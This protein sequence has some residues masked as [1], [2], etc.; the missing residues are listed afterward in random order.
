M[1]D[2]KT[3]IK[4]EL[5]RFFLS[6]LAYVYLISF[7]L[8]SGSCAIYFG[9]FFS[10]GNACLWD[11]FDYQPWIYLL[12]I[13]AI[14]MR[15]WA[16][17]FKSKTVI[18]LLTTPVAISRLVWGKFF[19]AWIFAAFAIM[20][21]FPFWITINIFGNPD[22]LVVL[23]GYLSC[24]ILAGAMLAI[25]QTMSA[26]TKNSVV[27]LVLSVFVNLIFFWS[28]FDF[29][30]FWVREIFS[31]TVIDTIMS[32]SFLAHFVSLNRGLIELRDIVF[33]SSLILFFNLLTIAIISLRTKG[34]TNF[35]SI[36]NL[37]KA[38]FALILLFIG[39]FS[40]NV[41]ANNI[42]RQISYDF[43]NEKYL[44]LT[45]STKD[46]LKN[47]P[48]P[49]VARLYYSPI[50]GQRNPQTRVLFNQIKLMLQQYKSFSQGKFDYKIYAPQFLDKIE[51]RALA[52]G[53]QPIPL[54][55]INQ[56]ALF[57]IVFSDNLTN[58]SVIPF[59]SPE[60]NAFLE[61]DFTTSIYSLFHQKKTV[62]ILSSL[63]IMGNVRQG[64]VLINKWEI[65]NKINEIYQIKEIVSPKDLDSPVDVLMLVHPYN[66]SK[67]FLEKIKQQ[68][69]VLL[70][71]DIA[72]DASR[73]YS[74]ENGAFIASDLRELADYWQIKFYNAGVVAD[75]DN[76]ITVDETINY[77]T[78]PSFTQ[79]L[80]QFIVT[81]E[82]LNPQHQIT[83]KL[84]NLMFS[85]ASMVYPKDAKKVSFFPLVK[86]SNNSALLPALLAQQNKSPK[87]VL[88]QFS[89]QDYTLILAAEF[90][91]N[92]PTH[93]FDVIAVGDTDFIYDSFW[94]KER[95]FLDTTYHVPFF[96]GANFILNAL[97]YL[98]NNSDLVNLRGKSLHQRF[99]FKIDKLRKDNTYQYKIKESEIFRAIDDVR[100]RLSQLTAKKN[101]EDRE[102]F[103]ADELEIIGK[104]RKE[105]IDLRQQLSALRLEMNKNISN[106]ELR[107]KFFDI[108]FISLLILI[109]LLLKQL[110]KIH[111]KLSSLGDWIFWDKKVLK[112]LFI[113][114]LLVVFAFFT[115]IANNQNNISKYED[116]PV[117][118]NFANSLNKITKIQLKSANKILTFK[119]K[120][121]IWTLSEY[122]S[123]PVYQ[124]RIRKFLFTINNM[125]FS[126]KKSD[127]IED[128]KYFGFSPLQ[129][130]KSPM[131]AVSLFDEQDNKM[132]AFDIGE[133]NLD[134]GRGSKAAYIKLDNQFQVWL[135]EADFYELSLDKNIWTYGSLWNL[136]FGRFI[137]YN[138]IMDTFK[139]MLFAK[140]LLNIDVINIVDAIDAEKI[141]VIKLD[142]ENNNFVNLIFYRTLDNKY[143]VAYDF[144]AKPQGQSL[145]FFASQMQNKYFEI[146]PQEWDTIKDD[147]IF[148]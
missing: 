111:L 102:T 58:K 72:N 129:D 76:S 131:I 87:E 108:Y 122:P 33:F 106:I 55:D 52:D 92:D 8:L 20:L 45:Q 36:N 141:G 109:F 66:L 35:I 50:L 18:P 57:G 89:P 147:I 117:F 11:L 142:I 62:G 118:K 97:D 123:F 6:P 135:A 120:N 83:H 17:E 42:F 19:A 88:E 75:F 39:F 47:I 53:L 73:L 90:L 54:I 59:F 121:N 95:K 124:D 51:D 67:D 43:T 46:I 81:K 79:D 112:L 105:L 31:D 2:I 99:L 56:N 28:G 78:N 25:S 1:N 91:S 15:T 40:L 125:T 138:G 3:V 139:I 113:V 128:L 60:R 37:K 14:S 27:A 77:K 148:L 98:T 137:G 44:S 134:L 26:L 38:I 104:I 127:R 110:T 13:P 61:Q 22:N 29:V 145:E 133:Y 74:P 63:P 24:I 49:I 41:I 16:D 143:Y 10:D 84:N 32:F 70:L 86:S 21:T 94:S 130:K 65:I 7:L 107:V 119:K 132:I 23:V 116:V 64:N 4:F 12:F 69:K 5:L 93:P 146:S 136:K 80:L 30:L 140:K 103:N 100:Q 144:V 34:S 126:E 96:D 68:Q 71:L 114:M 101:F 85:S 48:R 115:T 82:D 9:H